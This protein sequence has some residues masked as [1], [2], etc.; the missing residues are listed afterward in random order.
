LLA[1]RPT[2]DV[3]TRRA[4]LI[5]AAPFAFGISLKQFAQRLSARTRIS[6]AWRS[7]YHKTKGAALS[8]RPAVTNVTRRCQLLM[9]SALASRQCPSLSFLQSSA[10]SARATGIGMAR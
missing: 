10:F 1:R 8:S 2:P 7:A 9:A 3:V 4:V 6:A 5:W